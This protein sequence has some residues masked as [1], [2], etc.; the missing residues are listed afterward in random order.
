MDAA[1][2]GP[3]HGRQVPWALVQITN[4][5]VLRALGVRR[6]KEEELTGT[7]EVPAGPWADYVR[8]RLRDSAEWERRQG[9]KGDGERWQEKWGW[10][11][12]PIT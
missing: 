5:Y 7:A 11:D 12:T 10:L 4:L 9:G 8:G 1:E 6:A 3:L 2:C